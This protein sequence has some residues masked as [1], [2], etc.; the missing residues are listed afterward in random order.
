MAD[1]EDLF[2]VGAEQPFGGPVAQAQR[3]AER[4]GGFPSA[5]TG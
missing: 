1:V 4:G 3:L 5:V 2:D